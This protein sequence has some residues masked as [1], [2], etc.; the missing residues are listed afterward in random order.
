MNMN[1]DFIIE[2]LKGKEVPKLN[3][4]IGWIEHLPR[5][6]YKYPIEFKRGD[7]LMHKI[8]KHPYVLLKKTEEYWI[9]GLLTTEETFPDILQKC[10][11][12]FFHDGYFTRT[13]FTCVEPYG[14]FMG[15]FDNKDQI[16]SIYDS[17][18]QIF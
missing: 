6:S 11:S 1:K 2:K 15:V 7:V 5:T 16:K 17:L 8:F 9:C 4:L 12:R 13:I 18:T 10:E 3:D 14:S